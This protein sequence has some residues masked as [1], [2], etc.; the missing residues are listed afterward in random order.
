MVEGKVTT[1]YERVSEEFER[2]FRERGDL[3]ASFAAVRDGELVVDIWGGTADR[4]RRRPWTHD[5]LQLVLS[6]TKGMVALCILILIDRGK[7]DLDKPVRH[8]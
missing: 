2:N 6:G 8:Y 4:P 3:G 7:L 5:T 1:G